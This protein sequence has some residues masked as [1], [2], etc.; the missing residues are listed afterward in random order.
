[1]DKELT[2]LRLV[3]AQAAAAGMAIIREW[4]ESGRDI[5]AHHTGKGP[6][7]DYVTAVDYAAEEAVMQVLQKLSPKPAHR[8]LLPSKL[9]P[10]A[11]GRL[12]I[13]NP[14]TECRPG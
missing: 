2:N 13:R 1:M 10:R 4:R 6:G 5:Q 12:R 14:S 3:A 8:R 7:D 11:R 9:Q